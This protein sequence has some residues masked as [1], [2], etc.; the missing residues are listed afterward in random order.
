MN[1]QD[2]KVISLWVGITGAGTWALMYFLS[3]W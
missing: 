1:K 2:F 3:L